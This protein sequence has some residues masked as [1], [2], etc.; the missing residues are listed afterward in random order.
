ME[1]RKARAKEVSFMVVVCGRR[2]R[3]KMGKPDDGG[4]GGVDMV[5]AGLRA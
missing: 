2:R 3:M 4:F 5:A 1:A